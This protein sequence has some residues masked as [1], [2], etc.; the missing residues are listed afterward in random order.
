M[1]NE[2]GLAQ[3][4]TS[5]PDYAKKLAAGHELR[6]LL[7]YEAEMTG[8]D[9]EAP[10]P[11]PE[12]KAELL[13]IFPG[14]NVYLDENQEMVY[15]LQNALEAHGL[16]R[17]GRDYAVDNGE[18][19]IIDEFKGRISEGRRFTQGLHQALEIKEGLEIRPETRTVASIT[20][21]NL[22]RG[23]PNLAGMTGTAESA[24]EEF[25]EA[26][27]LTQG[28]DS[29][30]PGASAHR[31]SRRHF[32]HPGREVRRRH[33]QSPGSFRRGRA[34]SGGDPVG[35]DE[36]IRIGSSQSLWHPQ[37]EPRRSGRQKQYLPGERH[38]RYGGQSGVVTVATNMAGR[39]VDIKPD[40]LDY[41]KLAIACD[42]ARTRGEAVVVVLDP[43][44]PEQAERLKAWFQLDPA[45]QVPFDLAE[46]GARPQ[47]GRV[48]LSFGPVDGSATVFQGSDFPGKKLLVVA[49]ERDM[50]GASM[51]SCGAGPDARGLPGKLS[52]L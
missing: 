25:T 19:Q 34:G 15:C 9:T 31:P 33:G 27:G 50:I 41:K 52:S 4:S 8:G 37:S 10:I 26:L 30:Q 35:G 40:A 22:F 43:H 45:E 6:S 42:E 29:S 48:L 47:A 32:R 16:F 12:R 18:V 23:Y 46:S 1:A 17:E 20:Y 49:T 38:H 3:L 44:Q 14:V 39:G 51:T 5:D 21:P 2:V 28:G 24:R 13:K 7:R 36:P 11:D